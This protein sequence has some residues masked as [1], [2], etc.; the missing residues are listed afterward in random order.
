M[1]TTSTNK[2][3][4]LTKA[5]WIPA[6]A[7]G[8]FV[9]MLLLLAGCQA[10]EKSKVNSP[11]LT[12]AAET[13]QKNQIPLQQKSISPK[14]EKPPPTPSKQPESRPTL[15][16]LP[17]PIQPTPLVLE[18]EDITS[19]PV[20][21]ATEEPATKEPLKKCD[22]RLPGDDLLA[23]VTL[24][25]G[26][27]REFAPGD[28]VPLADQVPYSVTLGYPTEVREVILTPLVEMINDMLSAGLYPQILSGYRSYTAQVLAREKWENLYPDHVSII[29]APPGHSEHQLGTV[30]D[31]G[32]PEL[33]GIV[34]QPDIQFHTYFYKTS[35]GQWLSENAHKYGFTL[36]YPKEAI[37][38]TG[39]Y[40]E[41]WHYRYVGQ[42]IAE[43]LLEQET[44]L[45]EYQ[46]ANQ[47]PPCL[48]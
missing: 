42:S 21:A 32:S 4:G 6:A 8:L 30:I 10:Q 41:P 48:P 29:S 40:Y 35:E 26:L 15:R 3:A 38:I 5:K 34:G 23:L 18:V 37:E 22:E 27:N 7:V 39:F 33:P 12:P 14:E 28:L 2:W 31:F 46:L 9:V 13:P 16:P 44:S 36:S 19:S 43:Q 11:D 47:A 25:Y 24:D 20:P 45:I 17:S 1:R